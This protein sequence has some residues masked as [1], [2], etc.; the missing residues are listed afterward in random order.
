MPFTT[1]LRLS[2]AAALLAA[3]AQALAADVV[4]TYSVTGRLV[5]PTSHPST[6]SLHCP[7]N[8]VALNAAVTRKGRGA[9]VRRSVPG[10]GTGDWS[11]RIAATGSGSRAV[12]A[13]LRCVRLQVPAGLI[14]ARLDVRTRHQSSIDIAP[15]AT[16]R[17]RLGC[18]RAWTATGYALGGGRRN[19]VR[20]AEVVPGAH[21]WSFTLENTGSVKA[22]VGVSARCIRSRV[23][24]RSA[25]GG[26][27]ALAF[28]V[29]RQSRS[30]TVGPGPARTFSHRCGADRFSV[31]TGSSVDPLDP[32]ELALSSPARPGAGRWTFA[33][34]SAGDR[35]QSFLV[36]LSRASGFH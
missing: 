3:P 17:T 31:A 6:I 7:P 28:Q 25:R 19:N 9:V 26:A 10:H 5:A 34:A 36:C 11:F 16:M 14:G 29:S 15:G 4:R 33:H 20:L 35:V 30:N 12:S 32:I 13:V 1:V 22:H 27:A 8:A 21:E 18:G 23:T 2:V 24:A